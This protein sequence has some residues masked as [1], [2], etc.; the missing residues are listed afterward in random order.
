[1]FLVV[2]VFSSGSFFSI[3]EHNVVPGLG[4][5]TALFIDLIAVQA[6]RARLNAHRM[7]DKAGQ[8]LYLF[9][10]LLCAGASAF[11]NVYT[12]L[13]DFHAVA[14]GALPSWMIQV[15]PWFGLVFPA[16]ILLLS[17]TAD[18]T[19]DQTSTKLDPDSYETHEKKRLR[20]LEI[21]RDM[22]KQ[23][24]SIEQEIDAYS[25]QLKINSREF[26]LVHWLLPQKQNVTQIMIDQVKSEFTPWFQHLDTKMQQF[27][28]AVSTENSNQVLRVQREIQQLTFEMNAMIE[29]MAEQP[30]IETTSQPPEAKFPP[31][32]E[33][34]IETDA[35]LIDEVTDYL[36]QQDRTTGELPITPNVEQQNET[37]SAK[38]TAQARVKSETKNE[39]KSGRGTA[40]QKALRILQRNPGLSP[41]ELA[42]RAD[43]TPQYASKIL[44]QLG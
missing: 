25:S 10:V 36:K 18:Y 1:M 38:K 43:I 15:A 4:Y 26:F 40:Q 32:D 7:R 20:M 30:S 19:I 23:R 21:Q 42:R 17:V 8:S 41:V 22:L 34:E 44:K 5:V 33:T 39:T 2:S 16:L 13:S 31:V 27:V 9:G 28:S 14:S 12:S 11:A 29:M 6:M 35:V 3:I 24:A 37:V